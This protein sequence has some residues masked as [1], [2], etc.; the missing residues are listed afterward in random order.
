MNRSNG[1]GYFK[2][3]N[4][5]AWFNAEDIARALGYKTARAAIEECDVRNTRYSVSFFFRWTRG[6]NSKLVMN[7]NAAKR[8]AVESFQH[9]NAESV[10]NIISRI[11]STTGNAAIAS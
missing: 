2:D 5:N 3:K 4:G 7:A 11:D 1:I 10:F 8:I 6:R 9:W